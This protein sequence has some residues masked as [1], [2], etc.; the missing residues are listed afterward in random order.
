M[1]EFKRLHPVAIIINALKVLKETLIPI[2]ILILLPSN[3]RGGWDFYDLIFA[4][5][6]FVISI[7]SG[8]ITWFKFKYQITPEEIRLRKKVL[9]PKERFRQ[10][11]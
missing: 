5:V 3:G 11:R 6:Y 8:A 4:G 10:N 9:D 7:I 2:L 1:S